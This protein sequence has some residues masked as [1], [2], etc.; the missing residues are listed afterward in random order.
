MCLLMVQSKAGFP[1]WG[2]CTLKGTLYICLSEGVHLRLMIVR[3]YIY[4]YN[5][6]FQIICT[7]NIILKTNCM[8]IF[9]YIYD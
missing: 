9:K 6:Y 2:T 8:L 7:V 5:I 1:T 3:K 4:I